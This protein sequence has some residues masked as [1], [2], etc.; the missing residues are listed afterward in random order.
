MAG[1]NR[2]YMDQVEAQPRRYTFCRGLKI[3]FT[4]HADACDIASLAGLRAI[5]FNHPPTPTLTGLLMIPFPS[6]RD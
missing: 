6:P 4:N 5:Y 3:C 2:I 1:N